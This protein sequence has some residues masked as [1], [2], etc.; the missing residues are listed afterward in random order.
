MSL[1]CALSAAA[2]PVRLSAAQGYNDACVQVVNGEGICCSP[3]GP[4]AA[5]KRLRRTFC[6]VQG[7]RVSRNDNIMHVRRC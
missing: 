5:Q 7:S 6:T 3:H 1:R 2:C 4:E